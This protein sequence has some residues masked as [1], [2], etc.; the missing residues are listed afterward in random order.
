M[1]VHIAYEP[2]L[3]RLL[4]QRLLPDRVEFVELRDWRG[5]GDAITRMVVRGAPAIGITAAYGMALAAHEAR[6][7]RDMLAAL[8]SAAAGLRGARPTAVNLSWAVSRALAAAR[9]RFAEGGGPHP[10]IEAVEAA[11]R[12]MHDEDIAACRRI[13]DAGAALVSSGATLLTLCNTG[14]LATGGYGTA[15]GIVRS[16]HA[17]GR[18]ER[19]LVAETRPRLQGA[20]LTTW[21]LAQ[22]GIPHTLITDSMAAPF[23]R[24]GAVTAV[25]VGADR[26]AR[27]GDTANKI[28]TYAFAVL[29]DAH[30]VPFIIA[31]PISTF[32][33]ALA[34]GSAIPIEQRDG[35][36][37]TRIAGMPI[38][39]EGTHAANPAFDVTPARL[40]GAI[41]T[42]R[43]VARQPL[44]AA[45][46][47][48]LANA[49]EAVP[50]S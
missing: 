7:S 25:V 47:S 43:G 46:H 38:A 34:D 2:G 40:I 9:R 4:D 31:A 49:D 16:A 10:V 11:A 30:R 3:L 32:D 28:G 35:A 48:L 8:E 22:D 36:E 44:G 13:G 26:I 12:A 19:V 5:V 37:V 20:R 6:A 29:A 23:M 15:L 1:I 14:S 21:E 17:A 45:I 41:V 24:D 39:P 42:E 33:P 50:A 18:L 27:N